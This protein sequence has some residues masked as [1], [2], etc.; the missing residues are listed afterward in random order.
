MSPGSLVS[1]CMPLTTTC[2]LKNYP[3][4]IK[5]AKY[6]KKDPNIFKDSLK[7]K[8]F[9]LYKPLWPSVN[10]LQNSTSFGINLC[11]RVIGHS[12]GC[13]FSFLF[14]YNVNPSI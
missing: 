4:N 5:D 9:Q 14:Q 1:E 8:L 10:F 7:M 3:I 6:E 13:L 12:T 2:E 11:R